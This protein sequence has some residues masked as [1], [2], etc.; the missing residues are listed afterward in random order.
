[1]QVN[2]SGPTAPQ[3]T[4]N[5]TTQT[6][7]FSAANSA[8]TIISQTGK[9]EEGC[10]ILD[11]I[12]F[13]PRKIWNFVQW[14][15][16]CNT[17][18]LTLAVYL[19]NP[20]DFKRALA[21]DPIKGFEQFVDSLLSDPTQL[22]TLRAI[23]T[24]PQEKQS[25]DAK[26]SMTA[27]ESQALN[28]TIMNALMGNLQSNEFMR[29]LAAVQQLQGRVTTKFA[30]G[31]LEIL[32]HVKEKV[33]AATKGDGKAQLQTFL[34]GALPKL[35]IFVRERHPQLLKEQEDLEDQL[36]Q[37]QRESNP[38]GVHQLQRKIADAKVQFKKEVQKAALGIPASVKVDE[39]ALTQ[40]VA[41]LQEETLPLLVGV[42]T[43][44]L[45]TPIREVIPGCQL[46]L[47]KQVSGILDRIMKEVVL[48]FTGP[49]KERM[50]LANIV[51][52][53]IEALLKDEQKVAAIVMALLNAFMPSAK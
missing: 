1:M 18:P 29:F 24:D 23:V 3:S 44:A 53:R 38:Y 25:V 45:A 27:E 9:S 21:K 34:E 7:H 51:H 40:K 48:S 43:G 22:A 32:D 36:Q 52:T 41:T 46:D 37:A 26:Y 17:T 35:T 12:T 42:I 11:C 2:L 5:F 47:K 33:S 50:P 15:F 6:R 31:I 30:Q 13:I 8:S 4:T 28:D 19:D 39:E 16:C 20:D 10:S 49:L 14:L